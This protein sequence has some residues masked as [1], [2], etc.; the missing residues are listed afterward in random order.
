[1]KSLLLS[2]LAFLALAAHTSC[3]TATASE[4]SMRAGTFSALSVV[5]SLPVE[6]RQFPDSAGRVNIYASERA[7]PGVAVT[8]TDG[9]LSISYKAE[10][11]LLNYATEVQSVVVYCGRD[12]RQINL[13]GSGSVKATGVNISTELTVVATGSGS[14]KLM[15]PHC[16]NL[17]AS[18]TGSGSMLLD[19]VKARNVSTSVTGSGSMKVDAL[20]ATA[21]NCTLCGSGRASV[22]GHADK[23]S[24]ALRGSGSLNATELGSGSLSISVSGSGAIRY[25]TATANIKTVSGRIDG[26]GKASNI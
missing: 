13:T 12:L 1:M 21:F 7:L 14:V 16:L 6:L 23:S 10:S 18:L 19:A 25:N 3:V 2:L 17:T 9:T 26:R 8:C 24:L 4:R 5:G 15:A 20:D 11:P 22:A